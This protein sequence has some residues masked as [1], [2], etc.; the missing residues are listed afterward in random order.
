MT[1]DRDNE[2]QKT[3]KKRY[4]FRKRKNKKN[5]KIMEQ[6]DD[7]DSDWKPD[8]TSISDEEPENISEDEKEESFNARE[9]QKFIQKIFPSKS[10]AE[11]LNQLE[12]LDKLL[13]KE[14]MKKKKV[15]KKKKKNHMIV[16]ETKEP[17]EVE[18]KETDEETTDEEDEDTE[19]ELD[20]NEYLLEDEDENMDEDELRDMLANNMKFN[21]IFTIG[22]PTLMGGHRGLLEEDYYEEEEEQRL[23]DDNK[24][25]SKRWFVD[26]YGGTEEWDE[27]KLREKEGMEKFEKG[28]KVKIK[29]AGWDKYYR[30]II[31]KVCKNNKY[32]IRLYDK[33][34]DERNWKGIKGK[35]IKVAKKEVKE[36]D[37][38]LKEMGELIEIRKKK[39]KKA[40]LKKFD[41][42]VKVSEEKEKKKKTEDDI[43]E[44]NK[45]IIKF[46]SRLRE[47]NVMNDFKY[48][49]NMNLETQKKVLQ[50]L[51]DINKHSDIEKPYRLSILE[52]NIPVA[53]KAYAL[54]KI[55]ILNY[56]D[57]NS[58]EY[59]KIKQWVDTFMRIPFGKYNNLPIKMDDGI[60]KCSEFMDNAKAELDKCVYGLEDAKM[61]IMQLVGQWISNPESVGTAIAIKGPPGTGKT[62]LIKDGI[63][64]ILKRPLC[65][66]L[67]RGSN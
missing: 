63:S 24:L 41:A 1:T 36:D 28:Q 38:I 3:P 32:N 29:D 27:A 13:E 9:F 12:K 59:Y 11:R 6:S 65:F 25:Y 57:S 52:S 21:I 44:K 33:E 62:T 5:Y 8:D 42:F 67:T 58:G 46:R 61:Q 35:Y 64:A 18:E 45:N 2:K 10:G 66:S 43:K 31:T 15:V 53:F 16:K 7:S 51:E 23:A 37:Q 54:K 26:Y 55:N 49:R 17:N 50:N 19:V 56:M 60:D 20:T 30:G 40:M 14:S 39:G 22:D 48:F 47:K 34:L 4:N